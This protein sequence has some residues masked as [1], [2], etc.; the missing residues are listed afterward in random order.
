MR[1]TIFILGS[2]L[3]V[4][5]MVLSACQPTEVVK[6][7][8]V[9]VQ[10]T[11]Q[12]QVVTATPPPPPE[13]K[14][15]DPNT[16]VNVVFG[17][18]DTLDT[19]LD[20]ETAGGEI[21][22]NVYDTLITYDREKPT[23]FVPMLATE[24]SVSED[25][26]VYT[27][28]IRQGV[29]FHNGADMT[30]SDVAFTFI[31]GILQGGTSSPQWLL[32][33]PFFGVGVDDI[34]A[35]V[36][37][38]I[39]ASVDA[40]AAELAG[41][42]DLA[43]FSVDAFNALM[44]ELATYYTAQ[45]GFT[46][47]VATID[48]AAVE[49]F[50]TT[51]LAALATDDEKKAAIASKATEILSG[52]EG[53]DAYALYDDAEAMQRVN[54]EILTTVADELKAKIVADD[55][56]WTVTMTL[57][58]GWGPFIPTLANFWGAI[59]DSDWVKENGAWDG[60]SATWAKYYGFSAETS[61]LSNI[62]MG[63][64]PYMFDHWTKGQEIVLVR[65]PNY[66]VTEPLWR[67]A[68]TGAAAIERIVI[69]KVDEWGTRFAMLQTGDADFASVNR[70]DASQVDPFV[71]EKCVF[72]NETLDYDACAPT[73]T[74]DQP[75]RLFIGS[76]SVSRTDV[77][78]TFNIVNPEGGNPLLG[79]GQLD[80]NGIP[81][82]FFSDVHIRRA[83]NYCFDWD[84]YIQDALLGEAFQ[85]IG[86]PLPGMPGYDPNGPKYSFDADKCAEE[87]QLADL[88]KDGVPA[89][90]DDNDVWT[91]GFRFQAGYNIGNTVRQTIGEILASNINAVNEKFSVELV[92]LPWPTFLRNQRASMLPMFFSGWI[93]DIHDPHNWYQPYIIG[94]YG[95]R[96][97]LPADLKA[98][99]SALID[100]GV[101][102]TDPAK[103]NEIYA[104]LNQMLYEEAPQII[105]AIATGRHYEQRWI[106]G[107]YTNPITPGYYYYVLSK[108]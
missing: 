38:K 107:Y 37:D 47:D 60:D 62:A 83:F 85:S 19:A 11:P 14:S 89:G 100:Q 9:L 55:A 103:R 91:V 94:T 87:F 42:V 78:L 10:G 23:T 90:Q 75:L 88:D 51:D 81:P 59:V 7:V 77:F 43:A 106:G 50:V 5:S 29:K 46:V 71:G 80:G 61:P 63:T 105:L 58:Q 13:F 67:D 84:T 24:W 20:Y 52:L 3:V 18:P 86:V 16:L 54:V 95:R 93:E 57:A 26:T 28:T 34:A 40:K 22:Q 4:A 98:K 108:K 45:S 64:G 30:P 96:Q 36:A 12:I 6:T 101:A 44:A 53:G 2:L 99:F 8:E 33:E 66:W 76:P 39:I 70:V 49:T 69:K 1:K 25:G 104:Q 48:A 65:N 56:N 73:E 35:V 41:A 79:S 102:E 32:T 21:I 31:R 92:G 97:K 72:N 15:K 27:F 17:E 74:S 82:D 68:P